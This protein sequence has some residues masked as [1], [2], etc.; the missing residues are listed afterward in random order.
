MSVNLMKPSVNCGFSAGPTA[1]ENGADSQGHGRSH[2]ASSSC[3]R[4][5]YCGGNFVCV[6]QLI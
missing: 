2:E 5:V 3:V 4:A 6:I 1:A